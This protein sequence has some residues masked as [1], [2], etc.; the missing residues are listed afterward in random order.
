MLLLLQEKEESRYGI[1]ES[2]EKRLLREG[3]AGRSGEANLGAGGAVFVSSRAG[4][5]IRKV[6]L[7]LLMP[8][9][10][11]VTMQKADSQS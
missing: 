11:E 8:S 4:F 6:R 7:D 3:C 2:T 1:L 9:R 10:F 5:E